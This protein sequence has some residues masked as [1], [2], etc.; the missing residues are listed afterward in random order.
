M[1]RDQDLLDRLL[2]VTSMLAADQER[3]Q[4][5]HDLTGPR[6]HLLWHLGTTGAVRQADLA[7][8]LR[9]SPRN[10]TGLVD[11]L[12]ASGHVRREQHPTDRRAFLVTLTA[13]GTAF[14]AALRRQHR[15]LARDLFAELT[16]SRRADLLA[17]LDLVAARLANLMGE[18]T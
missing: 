11:G 12:V 5:E 13:S 17:S 7:A 2:L 18:E 16:D 10:I 14:I 4:R 8:A 15:D 1:S 6:V 9:V 3:F